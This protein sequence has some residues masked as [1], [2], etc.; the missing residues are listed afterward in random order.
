MT[1]V[2]SW[3]LL[4]VSQSPTRAVR[5][6]GPLANRPGGGKVGTRGDDNRQLIGVSFLT[7]FAVLDPNN[8]LSLVFSNGGEGKVGG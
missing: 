1:C 4:A 7:Q 3:C 2:Q 8:A 5:A 6:A